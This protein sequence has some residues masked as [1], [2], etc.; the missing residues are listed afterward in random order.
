MADPDLQL[1]GVRSSRPWDKEGGGT[2][3]SKKILDLLA[4]VWS[5][6]KVGGGFL[7]GSATDKK[8]DCRRLPP[9]IIVLFCLFILITEILSIQLGIEIENRKWVVTAFRFPGSSP[10]IPQRHLLPKVIL[11]F[12]V[13]NDGRFTYKTYATSLK[14][15]EK[16]IF[17]FVD[18][19]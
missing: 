16:I 19:S 17:W 14:Q 9:F 3:S 6:N 4:S 11:N 1:S 5:K 2:R 10:S 8:L 18:Q 13:R 7:P 15:F 12:S